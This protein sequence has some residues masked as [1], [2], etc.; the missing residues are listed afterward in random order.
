[1]GIEQVVEWFTGKP[2]AV[3]MGANKVSKW[4]GT[5]PE[6]VRRAKKVFRAKMRSQKRG[7]KILIFDIETAPL[8]ALVYQKSVWKANITSEQIES[9]WFMLTWSAKWLFEEKIMSDR[10]TAEEVVEED[11][12]RIAKTLWRLLDEADIVI[13]HNGDN[14][15]VPNIN[16]RFLLNDL[17]PPRL[18][19]QIDTKKVATRQFGFTHNSLDGLAKLFGFNGKKEVHFELWR[20][21]AGRGVSNKDRNQAL[22]D[23]ELYNQRDVSL[24][25]EVY[26]KLRPWIKGHPNL[27]LLIEGDEPRCPVCLSDDIHIDEGNY[28]MTSV[29]KFPV[30]VCRSCG[31]SGRIR[32]SIIP[33]EKRKQMYVPIAR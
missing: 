17:P 19:Q 21:C 7:A 26:L 10:L 30:A 4:I 33:K 11:D 32:Q 12:K 2:Y 9:E 3:D 18:Y 27:N 22:K 14:F 15:D 24:L 1:M 13:A 6:T 25:E 29:S 8:T 5:T 28:Y 31:N 16:T 20:R 23:M